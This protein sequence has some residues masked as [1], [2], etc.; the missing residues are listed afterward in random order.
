M[1]DQGRILSTD[2]LADET[3]EG[4]SP[5]GQAE[6]LR[7]GEEMVKATLSLGHGADFGA[8]IMMGIFGTL[9]VAL[10][11]A[12]ATLLAGANQFWPAIIAGAATGAGLFLAAGFCA[13]AAWPRQFFVAGFEP[14]NL[15]NSS[16]TQDKYRGRVLIA[17]VQDRIDENRRAIA[18]G[19]R[20]VMIAIWIAAVSLPGGAVL[21]IALSVAGGHLAG[22]SVIQDHG[23]FGNFSRPNG[24][25]GA[26]LSCAN[27]FLSL[28]NGL[29]GGSIKT[30]GNDPKTSSGK[31][32]H[33][34]KPSYPPVWV[35][36]PLALFLGIGSNGVLLWGLSL[37]ER[38]WLSTA[39][40][41]LAAIMMLAGLS[42]MF[43]LG[44][45]ATWGW[46]I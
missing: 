32:E 44:V 21:L 29:S 17:V 2:L 36:I 19:A 7:S 11:A 39:I 26:S 41:C 9:G 30:A 45:R 23:S 5:E 6:F 38:R 3:W 8:I 18:R 35:R 12:I 16:A 15:V 34:G 25:D 1:P 24:G 43:A 37:D 33:A 4:V 27:C 42:L 46:W 13:A 40:V 10:F 28:D 14:R 22:R 31:K 20:L